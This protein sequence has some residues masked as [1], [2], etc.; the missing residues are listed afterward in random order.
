MTLR[1]K[2]S[3]L[4]RAL[5]GGAFDDIL[6]EHDWSGE[7]V[8]PLRSRSAELLGVELPHSDGGATSFGHFGD[9][10]TGV[11]FWTAVANRLGQIR[12]RK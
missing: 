5:E 6:L 8:E 4:F 7:L 10:E 1:E 3:L 9:P 11:Y 12:R 2:R